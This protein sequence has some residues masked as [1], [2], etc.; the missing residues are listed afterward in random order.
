MSTF[1]D[2][3]IAFNKQLDFTGTLPAGISIMNP[4]KENGPA[5]SV[6]T[7]FYHKYYNDNHPRHLILGINP[8]RFG[9][10]MTGVSFTDPKR[11]INECHIPYPGHLTHEPSSEYV[12]EMIHA[13]GGIQQFYE[14]FYIH[15]VC[16][17]GFTITGAN[18]KEVN[19]NYYDKPELQKAVY[20]FIIENLQKQIELGF[21]TDIC[22]CFGIGKNEAFLRK[23]N[24]EQKFFKEIIALEHPRYIMQYKA[25]TKQDYIAKY[26]RE[27][28]KAVV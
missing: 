7:Q 23:L 15:S 25:K 26:L 21:E 24:Q 8:G 27:L 2:R 17:L 1:A 10:G 11:M 12:Y 3:I 13:F 20:P 22:F 9:S 19:Y 4:F 16:P 5:L 28:S 6:S 18:N 14:Q